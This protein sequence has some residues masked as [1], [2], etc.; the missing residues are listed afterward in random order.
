MILSFRLDGEPIDVD[1][2]P[3]QSLLELLRDELGVRRVRE[4]CGEGDCGSCLV[5]VD[6]RTVAACLVPALHVDGRTVTTLQGLPADRRL[7]AVSQALTRLG[8]AQCGACAPGIAMA[9]QG[10]PAGGAPPD[11]AAVRRVLSGT[12]CRCTGY[13]RLVEALVEALDAP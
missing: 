1:A 2:F 5:Q 11:A 8:A 6:G 10:I 4:H 9:V 12:H 3:L 13:D 7:M